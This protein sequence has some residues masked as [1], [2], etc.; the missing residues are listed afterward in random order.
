MDKIITSYDNLSLSEGK[1]VGL[2][3]MNNLTAILAQ[4][5]KHRVSLNE[6]D[7][8]IYFDNKPI[9]L[10]RLAIKLEDELAETLKTNFPHHK[11]ADRLVALAQDNPFHPIKNVSRKPDTRRNRLY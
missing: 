8:N 7:N 6:L 9:E 4:N 11:I 5:L 10:K 3:L 2:G 1:K